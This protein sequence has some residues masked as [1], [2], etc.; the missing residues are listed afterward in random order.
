[1][2]GDVTGSGPTLVEP[3]A[4]LVDTDG[5]LLVTDI[6]LDTVIR[7]D[8]VTGNRTFVPDIGG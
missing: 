4:V 7:I 6:G 8:P 1:M 3:R 2:V 5:S